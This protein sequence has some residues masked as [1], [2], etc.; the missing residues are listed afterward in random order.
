MGSERG[1]SQLKSLLAK[2]GAM[3]LA[4][5]LVLLVVQAAP[6]GVTASGRGPSPA[7]VAR[8]HAAFIKYMSDHANDVLPGK[9]VLP[10]AQHSSSAKAANGTVVSAPSVNWSGFADVENSTT[11]TFSYVSGTWR[12][13]RMQCLSY[14]YQNQD[15]FLANWV[16]L[17]GATNG[18]V[19]QLGTG[20]QCYEDVEY[21]YVWYEMF[22]AGMVE[23]GT[24]ACINDNVNC[25]RPGDE[26]SASVKVTPG[27]GGENNYVLTLIDHTRPQESFSTAQQCAADVCADA[28]A[29]WILERP[30]FELPFGFQILPMGDFG[31]S[32]FQA[33]FEDS[34]GHFSSIGGF[35]DG[36]IENIDMNDDSGGYFIDCVGQHAPPG[37]LLLYPSGCPLVGPGHGGRFSATWDSSF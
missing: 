9:E 11:P 17:D 5:P 23:E 14:P 15:V 32:G 12:I 24:A 6:Q 20:S 33:A 3:L 36:P 28:S 29:E 4:A 22:P 21:Y 37:T 34:G 13:P 7:T 31:R 18:T 26:V 25:P 1:E 19:E 35:Q 27:T 10:G 8:A 2:A 30:A 16:G